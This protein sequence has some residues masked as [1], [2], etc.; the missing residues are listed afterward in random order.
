MDQ[1]VWLPRPLTAVFDHLAA[2]PQLG[3]WLP[4]VAAVDA[5][6]MP[7]AGVGAAFGLRLHRDGREVAVAGELIAYEPPWS[8]AYRLTAGSHTHVLRL[9]CTSAA[10]G[11]RVRVRQA[12]S[13]T[14]L[15]VDLHR[16]QA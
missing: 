3:D 14:P 13:T 16:L 15:A 10:G 6:A 9:T 5:D 8:V 2:P 7:L 12:D 11:T 1:E 4:E